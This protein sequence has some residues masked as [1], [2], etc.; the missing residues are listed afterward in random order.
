MIIEQGCVGIDVVDALGLQLR[1]IAVGRHH[2]R[3]ELL[4][5]FFDLLLVLQGL[6]SLVLGLLLYFLRKRQGLTYDIQGILDQRVG[7]HILPISERNGGKIH[8]H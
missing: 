7:I 4:E 8:G 3:L 2:K 5:D 1:L 6:F